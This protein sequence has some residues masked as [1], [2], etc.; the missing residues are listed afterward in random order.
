M[1]DPKGRLA[2]PAG[3]HCGFLR[4]YTRPRSALSAVQNAY[5]IKQSA[6][7]KQSLVLGL[8]PLRV[9]VIL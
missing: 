5:Y 2:I 6:D 3:L 1:T 8:I 4:H 7:P 9:H